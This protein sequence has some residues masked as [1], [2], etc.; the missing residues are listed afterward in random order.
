MAFNLSTYPNFSKFLRRYPAI[1][2][3]PTDLTFSLSRDGE[4]FR[5]SGNNLKTLFSQPSRVLDPNFWRLVYDVLRFNA[6]ARRLIIGWNKN[7]HNDFSDS[8]S[9]GEYLDKEGYSK[10]FRD[11]YLIVSFH[12]WH[13]RTMLTAP[14]SLSL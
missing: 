13:C 12:C 8:I 14:H 7:G 9:I 3:L 5:W 6:C 2:V 1:P 10:S 11:N 4:S